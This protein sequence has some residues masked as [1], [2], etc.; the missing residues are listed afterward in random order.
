MNGNPPKALWA[1]VERS[2]SHGV[3]GVR[4]AN[5]NAGL[6]RTGFEQ[7]PQGLHVATASNLKSIGMFCERRIRSRGP[8]LAEQLH[9][10]K[11]RN[12][13]DK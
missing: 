7:N 12:G 4:P 1:Q 3:S 2:R 11:C 13:G 10:K 5:E 9:A 6:E 8:A